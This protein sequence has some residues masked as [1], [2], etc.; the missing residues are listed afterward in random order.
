MTGL[1]NVP[2]ALTLLRIVL[3]P[4]IVWALL[5]GRHLLALF[6]TAL[7]GLTD[8]FDGWIAKRF[9]Q[10]TKVGAYLDPFADKLLLLS[11]ML[12]LFLTDRV[13]LPLFL[14]V[15]FRDVII[16]V[17]ALAYELA[18][19]KLEMAPLF[20]SKLTT[21]LQIVFVLTAMLNSA[22]P[23]PPLLLALVVWSTFAFTCISGLQYMLLWSRKAISAERGI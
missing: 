4:V 6:L 14:A 1:L 11:T 3:V 5:T 9:N 7:A 21:V 12:I 17:G 19:R 8:L 13:P 2:N 20:S 18:T 22:W 16:V 10:Q 15:L 23:L